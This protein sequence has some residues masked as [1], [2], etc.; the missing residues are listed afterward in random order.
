MTWMKILLQRQLELGDRFGRLI[1]WVNLLIIAVLLYEVCMRYL[2][3]A[4]TNWAHEM[5]TMLFGGYCLAAGVYTQAYD[6][7]VKIDV[8]YHL[9][10]ERS[11]AFLDVISGLFILAGFAF[12][13]MISYQYA[14]DSWILSEV[15]SK[16][17]W[18]PILFPIKAV[19]PLTVFLLIL[20]QLIYFL[21]DVMIALRMID[22]EGEILHD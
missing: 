14:L 22:R 16:S 8:I 20:N 18:R 19:I 5:S 2:F 10:G 9:F 6:K 7:H 13:F 1:S 17:S 11:R 15:S 4:P 3:S 12:L 21:R